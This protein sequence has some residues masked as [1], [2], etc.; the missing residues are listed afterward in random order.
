MENFTGI[1]K[2]TIFL[3]RETFKKTLKT[4]V[5]LR[6]DTLP[7][8]RDCFTKDVGLDSYSVLNRLFD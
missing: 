1:S 8:F 5:S 6:D 4:V 3:R 2:E 7:D